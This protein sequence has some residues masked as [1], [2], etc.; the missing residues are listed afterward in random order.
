MKTIFR[1]KSGKL[2]PDGEINSKVVD[3]IRDSRRVSPT[4]IANDERETTYQSSRH[5]RRITTTDM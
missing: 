3:V 2:S 5:G 4:P 1:F